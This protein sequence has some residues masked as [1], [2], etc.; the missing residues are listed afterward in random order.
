M[1]KISHVEITPPNAMPR[2]WRSAHSAREAGWEVTVIGYGD[3]CIMDGIHFIGF[4]PAKSRLQRMLIRSR[5]MVAAAAKSDADIVQLHSPEL[6]L[7]LR[8]LKGK[9]VIFDSHEFYYKQI[10]QKQYI[11][12]VLRHL[13]SNLYLQIEKYA[14]GKVEAVLFPCTLDGMLPSSTK[15][16]RRCELIANYSRQDVPEMGCLEKEDAI[17]YAGSLTAAEE[18]LCWPKRQILL[19]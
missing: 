7:Y 19:V 13:V 1:P 8:L 14:M 18:L 9:K 10:E 3:S 2:V 15:T 11:P 4:P 5:E 6:L 17:V 12:S 16:A